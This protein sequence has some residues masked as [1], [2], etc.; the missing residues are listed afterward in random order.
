MVLFFTHTALKDPSGL[1]LV[2]AINV[3]VYVYIYG[4]VLC[5]ATTLLVDVCILPVLFG[6]QPRPVTG[7]V[8][9]FVFWIFSHSLLLTG[10]LIFYCI[11]FF[12]T[13]FF[14]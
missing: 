14:F 9:P 4:G 5:V 6:F 2:K 1:G 13:V 3:A 10:S 11:Y 8:R 7:T 12:V